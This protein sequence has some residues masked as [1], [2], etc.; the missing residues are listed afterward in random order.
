MR[1]Q[2][3]LPLNPQG[4]GAAPGEPRP[5]VQ[6]RRQLHDQHELAVVQRRDDDELSRAD[7]ALAV[8]NFVSAAAGIAVAIALIRGFARHE[9]EH[10]RQLLGGPDARHAVRPA[11]DL[12]R[13]GARSCARR[14][15]SRTSTRT[16][17][18][19]RSKARRR[20]SRRDR[21]RRRKRSS[22]SAPTAAASSTPT[23]RIRS[24]ARRRSRTSF[25]CC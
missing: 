25:R 3:L 10:D 24:R 23:R 4:F 16:P 2:G 12:D 5:G 21:W 17:S 22:S 14:A 11:A 15:S 8:Q 9:T 7:G 13:R 18:P 19:R 1:L 6:H 20:R